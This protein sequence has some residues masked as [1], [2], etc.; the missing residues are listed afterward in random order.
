M[1]IV[2]SDFKRQYPIFIYFLILV[3]NIDGVIGIMKHT[4]DINYKNFCGK[5]A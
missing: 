5:V 3:Q 2:F 4:L 1:G